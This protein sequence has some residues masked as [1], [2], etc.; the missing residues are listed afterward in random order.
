MPR[1]SGASSIPRCR[2]FTVRLIETAVVTGLPAFAVMA[3]R[4]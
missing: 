2:N 4:N 3:E 1:E